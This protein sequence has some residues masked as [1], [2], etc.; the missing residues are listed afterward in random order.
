M[1]ALSGSSS[2]AAMLYIPVRR[3]VTMSLKTPD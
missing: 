1:Q 3:Q 2:T